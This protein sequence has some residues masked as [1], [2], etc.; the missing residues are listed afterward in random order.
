M[1]ATWSNSIQRPL[2]FRA[3]ERKQR[4][5]EGTTLKRR[6]LEEMRGHRASRGETQDPLFGGAKNSRLRSLM[7][8]HFS[9]DWRRDQRVSRDILTCLTH[10]L[11][12]T[13]THTC[14]TRPMLASTS[15]SPVGRTPGCHK[16]LITSRLRGERFPQCFPLQRGEEPL[17]T[18]TAHTLLHEDRGSSQLYVGSRKERKGW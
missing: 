2:K 16:S 4:K 11:P 17:L 12:H 7:L 14:S 3:W 5:T 8:K 10:T 1:L 13:H 6:S 9:E 15:N 18:F